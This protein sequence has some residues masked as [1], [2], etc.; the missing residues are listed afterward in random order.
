MVAIQELSNPEYH[1]HHG[2]QS[3]DCHTL[4]QKIIHV[5]WEWSWMW[6]DS[7]TISIVG[8]KFC[9]VFERL[10]RSLG[11]TTWL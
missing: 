6:A 3:G 7:K 1:K 5:L 10:N 9:I 8:I 11:F 2:R 4:D